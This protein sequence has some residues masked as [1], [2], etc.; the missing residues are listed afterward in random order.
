MKKEDIFSQLEIGKKYLADC[1]LIEKETNTKDD[2]EF[3]NTVC[4][5][6]NL[7]P[8]D[9]WKK[10]DFDFAKI[11]LQDAFY[12]HLKNVES[13]ENYQEKALSCKDYILSKFTPSSATCYTNVSDNPWKSN[14][15]H[16]NSISDYSSDIAIIFTDNKKIVFT[17]FIL[18]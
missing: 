7:H 9:S 8:N 14:S 18:D 15:H 12:N 1:F 3:L 5:N 16:F 10:I 13:I 2:I 4:K 11:L 6:E 17:Y